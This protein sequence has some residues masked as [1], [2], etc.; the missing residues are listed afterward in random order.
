MSTTK[1]EQI[2]ILVLKKSEYSTWKVKMLMFLEA[3][4]PDILD[5]IHDGPHEP[6]KLV[7]TAVVDGTTVHEHYV[8]KDKFEW[9][10]EEKADVLKDAKVKN[11]LHN[12]LDAVI[13]N[14]VITC[15]T[16]KE[17]WDALEVQ[18]QGTKSIK[19]NIRAF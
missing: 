13:S 19:K 6:K 2:R 5:R 7:P 8:A 17:I 4:D 14:R 11:I 9:T 1:Y 16:A 15:K 10:Y 3:T 18:F 12:S